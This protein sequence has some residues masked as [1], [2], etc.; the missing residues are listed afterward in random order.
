MN[1]YEA[2]TQ[3]KKWSIADSENTLHALRHHKTLP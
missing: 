2:K 1:N 3:F